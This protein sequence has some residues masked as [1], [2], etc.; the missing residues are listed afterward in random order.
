MPRICL[1]RG[2]EFNQE[3]SQ[4]EGSVRNPAEFLTADRQRSFPNVC[5]LMVE[6]HSSDV[7]GK[8][9]DDLRLAQEND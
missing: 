3:D 7:S 5:L 9:S 1:C 2:S 8:Q 4:R 6:V